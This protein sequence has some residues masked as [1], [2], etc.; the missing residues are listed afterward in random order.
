[1]RTSV[2]IPKELIEE[3]MKLTGASTQ[4]QAIKTALQSLVDREKRKRLLTFKGKIDLNVD[5][6][7]LRDRK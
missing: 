6:D 3:V 2:D 1:M 5:L 7:K 4:N